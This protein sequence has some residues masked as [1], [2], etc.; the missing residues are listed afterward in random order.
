MGDH[1]FWKSIRAYYA[2]YAGKNATTDDLRKVFEKTSG[3]LLQKFF[4]QWLYTAGH[5]VL[6]IKWSYDEE[7]KA[8]MLQINQL[9]KTTFS[10]PMQFLIYQNK[11]SE[12]INK[13]FLINEST[14]SLKISV[15]DKPTKIIADPETNLL[16]EGRVVEEK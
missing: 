3:L 8:V 1:L 4:N 10:F 16:Y 14:T 6:E 13:T 2:A 12:N 11:K 15:P 9:Q 7:K 5:P